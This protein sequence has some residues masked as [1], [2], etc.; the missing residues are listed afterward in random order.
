MNQT[1]KLVK[2]GIAM[3]LLLSHFLLQQEQAYA[4]TEGAYLVNTIATYANPETGLIVD[5]GTNLA[6]GESAAQSITLSTALVEVTE[7]RT[8]VTIGLGSASNIENPRIMLQNAPG[9]DA[10][11]SVSI[12]QTGTS[13]LDEDWVM[14]LRFEMSDPAVLIS[15]IIYVTPMGRDVQF[16]IRLDLTTAASGTGIFLSEM[17]TQ[18]TPEPAVSEPL[19]V[20]IETEEVEVVPELE[21]VEVEPEEVEQRER[22]LVDIGEIS[23][24]GVIGLRIHEVT[25]DEE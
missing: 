10:Y 20:V 1:K 14:H 19:D 2:L 17:V 18:A 13:T 16:F 21:S 9:V 8:F 25:Q 23:L 22:E 3:L 11:H 12:T 15:P 24:E 4:L 7:E 5:G 6:L